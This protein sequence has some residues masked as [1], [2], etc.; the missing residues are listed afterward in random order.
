MAPLVD[1]AA[2]WTAQRPDEPSRISPIFDRQAVPL[3]PLKAK[4]FGNVAS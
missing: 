2:R 4:T 1:H 3:A